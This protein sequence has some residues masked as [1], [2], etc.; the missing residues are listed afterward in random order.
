M[1]KKNYFF[2]IL[3]RSTLIPWSPPLPR[4]ETK[5]VEPVEVLERVSANVPVVFVHWGLKKLPVVD[6]DEQAIVRDYPPLAR[7]LVSIWIKGSVSWWTKK[8]AQSFKVCLDVPLETSA[9]EGG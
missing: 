2:P 3:I 7:Y 1:K 9:I 5:T 8:L 4:S 6:G